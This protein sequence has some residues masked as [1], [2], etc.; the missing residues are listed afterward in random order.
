MST[1]KNI[2]FHIGET[3]AINFVAHNADGSVMSLVGAGVSF[4]LSAGAVPLFTKSIGDGIQLTDIA[5]GAGTV[6]ITPEDQA[7]QVAIKKNKSFNYELKVDAPTFVSI[8]AIGALK[9]LPSLFTA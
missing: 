4:R 3:W 1:T 8:Q 5:G 7:A 9:V 2:E 6:T